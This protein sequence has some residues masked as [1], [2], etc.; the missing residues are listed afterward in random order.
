MQYGIGDIREQNVLAVMD[1]LAASRTLTRRELAAR[2][3]L[4]LTTVGKIVDELMD[5]G[6]L[7]LQ[8]ARTG[9]CGRVPAQLSFSDAALLLQFHL[10]ARGYRMATVDL[11]MQLHTVVCRTR[12]AAC[13]PA[14]EL[15]LFL[16][17]CRETL[18]DAAGHILLCGLCADTPATG[19]AAMIRDILGH[20]PIAAPS[21]AALMARAAT[22][23]GLADAARCTVILGEDGACGTVMC[24]G[25]VRHSDLS[26]LGG[27][28]STEV[29]FRA[30][31]AVCALLAPDVLILC[32]ER[33]SESWRVQVCEAAQRQYGLRPEV[34]D[35]TAFT[36]VGLGL[37]LREV[38][39][40]RIAQEDRALRVPT[41][42]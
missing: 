11:R 15:R 23:E 24:R 13:D 27:G 26:P 6:V 42:Q 4:S 38:W 18:A 7:S 17:D 3:G 12:H 35:S 31:H 34:R 19:A 39:L 40:A 9:A 14:E 2:C 41:A 21:P 16:L 30:M 25:T 33:P 10:T 8:R 28:N 1:A 32:T 36:A 20:E 29:L 37:Y 22:W 5:F